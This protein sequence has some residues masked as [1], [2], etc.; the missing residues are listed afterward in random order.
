M[1]KLFASKLALAGAFMAFGACLP[2][3]GD[4]LVDKN[5]DGIADSDQGGVRAPDTILL[6]APSSPVGS[7]Y[8]SLQNGYTGEIVANQKIQ[9]I[10]AKHQ[11]LETTTDENGGFM[12]DYVAPGSYRLGAT[13]DGFVPFRYNGTLSVGGNFDN[14]VDYLGRVNLLPSDG[15]TTVTFLANGGPVPSASVIV[16]VT[17]GFI[18]RRTALSA[19]VTAVTPAEFVSFIATTNDQGTAQVPTVPTYSKVA[20][21]QGTAFV[22]V[23]VI[24]PA[25]DI[26]GDGFIDFAGSVTQR[27]NLEL[28]QSGNGFVVATPAA[29]QAAALTVLATN[30]IGATGGQEGVIFLSP[31]GPL[32]FVFNQPIDLSSVAVS[33]INGFADGTGNLNNSLAQV[34]GAR[35]AVDPID[36]YTKPV[37]GTA[38]ATATTDASGTILR[39]TPA[40]QFPAGAEIL[41]RGSVASAQKSLNGT[42]ATFEFRQD[43]GAYVTP[44][45]PELTIQKVF[46]ERNVAANG[47]DAITIV[48]SKVVR[49]YDA[50]QFGNG[51]FSGPYVLICA[52]EDLNSDGD[53]VTPSTGILD[54]GE[55]PSDAN[56]NYT[57]AD[58]QQLIPAALR[59]GSAEL[60]AGVG[61]FWTF[62]EGDPNTAAVFNG[63]RNSLKLRLV[64]PRV[65]NQVF[66]DSNQLS[67]PDG[68]A[69][70]YGFIGSAD[71]T[72]APASAN[73]VFNLTPSLFVF[74]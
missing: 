57:Y 11:V 27:S 4:P 14:S 8:G 62:A 68:N 20:Q 10:T 60:R 66:V 61:Q 22:A 17:S 49:G 26:N 47:F 25:I 46:V 34:P 48:T 56:F 72:L 55:C 5:K 50:G 18:D 7:V 38:T 9:I 15:T 30:A 37:S 53:R 69:I 33:I 21:A 45:A 73:L 52:D 19:T 35:A 54:A 39:I 59:F 3:S 42:A 32:V 2:N 29:V 71:I 64:N 28:A 24:A 44:A 63:V 36:A 43:W 6:N 12:F 51:P 23:E 74:Q 65:Q 41:V 40:N 13:V 31:G 58:V 16:N 67:S 1:R 70:G